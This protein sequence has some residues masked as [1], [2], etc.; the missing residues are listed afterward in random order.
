MYWLRNEGESGPAQIIS[1]RGRFA[2]NTRADGEDAKKQTLAGEDRADFW[3][4][5]RDAASDEGVVGVLHSMWSRRAWRLGSPPL[6]GRLAAP[7]RDE[8]CLARA[9]GAWRHPGDVYF[10]RLPLAV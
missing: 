3:T 6:L 5:Q 1:Y 10:R 4:L 9:V 7:F 2:A 8:P